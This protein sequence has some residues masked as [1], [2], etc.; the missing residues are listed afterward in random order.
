MDPV[1][2]IK[3]RL[4]IVEVISQYIKM[5]KAGA[6]Y[7][8]RCPFHNEKTASFMVSPQKQIWHCF[9]CQKGGDIFAFVKEIEGVEFKDALK[10]L[11]DKAGVELKKNENWAQ[12]KS[13]RTKLLEINN[14]SLKFFEY[15]LENSKKGKEAKEYLLKR[16]FD[17][18]LIHDWRI[19]YAPLGYSN[20]SEFLEGRGYNKNYIEKAGV[21]YLGAKGLT[22][23]FRS[24]IIFPFFNVNAEIIGFTG[25]IFGEEK[26]VAKYLNTP[27]TIIYDKSRALFGI[28]KAKIPIR[29][30]DKCILVEGNIDCILSHGAGVSNVVAVS[31]TALTDMHL[32]IISRY[33]NNLVFAFDMDGAGRKATERAIDL[34][35]EIGFNV[36]IASLKEGKDPADIIVEDGAKAWKDFLDRAESAMDFYFKKAFLD[37]DLKKVEDIKIITKELLPKIKRMGNAIEQTHFLQ[38]L[39]DGIN[40]REEDL[41]KELAKVKSEEKEIAEEEVILKKEN[42]KEQLEKKFL[43]LLLLDKKID[44]QEKLYLFSEPYINFLNSIKENKDIEDILED[45]NFLGEIVL[46]AEREKELLQENETS[47]KEEANNCFALLE[48]IYFDKLKEDMSL[49]MKNEKDPQKKEELIKEYS[50]LIKKYAKDQKE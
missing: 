45:K 49:K 2:E 41:R 8:A 18:K 14:Q 47:I 12:E 13:E 44:L 38:R 22:D 4:D 21:A 27:S 33:T 40:A 20:L 39:A 50:N 35:R 31:G 28:H 17:E 6:N 5:E 36:S 48:K 23:R 16:G 1:E 11:A 9:G 37:K 42:Q 34:A 19:G 30:E 26:D 24:R 15:Y 32:K 43:K 10:I 7:R 3:S 25:R 29:E 46:G